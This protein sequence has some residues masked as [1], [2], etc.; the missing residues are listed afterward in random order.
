MDGVP[1]AATIFLV[2]DTIIGIGL[3]FFCINIV[4]TVLK[5]KLAVGIERTEQA[6]DDKHK[7]RS[8]DENDS[9]RIDLLSSQDIQSGATRWVSILGISSWFPKKYRSAVPTVSIVVVGVFV[10]SL[11]QLVG[12]I[13]LFT[14]LSTGFIFLLSPNFEPNW[15]FTKDAWWF[16]GHPIVYFTLFSFLGAVYYYI[17]KYAKKTV[18]MINGHTGLGRSI[19]FSQ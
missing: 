12:N 1:L 2:A 8:D 19:L 15:L 13:G 11:V 14:Q 10:N 18:R 4:L 9:G 3:M 5:G 16:F 17:P 7:Y 6:D